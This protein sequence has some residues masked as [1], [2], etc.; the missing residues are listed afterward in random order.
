MSPRPHELPDADARLA[1]H[2]NHDVIQSNLR[3][4]RDAVPLGLTVGG[5]LVTTAE[6]LLP[7]K[8]ANASSASLV[9]WRHTTSGCRWSSHGNNRG[10]RCLIEFTFHVANR[11]NPR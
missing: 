7:G 2:S 11:T 9:S 10:T 5:E 3:Q 6:E 1:G 4:N 8:F